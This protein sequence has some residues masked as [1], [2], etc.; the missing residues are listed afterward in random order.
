MIFALPLLQLVTTAPDAPRAQEAQACLD[1][2]RRLTEV[3]PLDERGDQ[4]AN[5]AA[6]PATR[7]GAALGQGQRKAIG[8]QIERARAAGEGGEGAGCM[9]GLAQARAG[10]REGGVGGAQPGLATGDGL[11]DAATGSGGSGGGGSSTTG[12]G[13]VTGGG[14]LTGTGGGV[15]AGGGVGSSTGGGGT[16]GAG[17]SGGGS[18]GGGS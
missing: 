9:A 1:E 17:S 11:G 16:S 5:I 10:L 2:V 7:K 12:S 8:D 14:S 6:Q 4:A 3:F 15:G 18:S 13:G